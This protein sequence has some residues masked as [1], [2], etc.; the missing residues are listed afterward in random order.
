MTTVER[1]RQL[2]HQGNIRRVVVTREGRTMAAFPLTFGVI[3]AVIAPPLAAILLV[4]ALV[5]GCSISVE[6]T[7][8]RDDG[9]ETTE[10]T[11]PGALTA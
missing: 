10:H 11:P 7:D 6:R 4:A 5:T 3:G 2:I 9:G 1:A 8:R